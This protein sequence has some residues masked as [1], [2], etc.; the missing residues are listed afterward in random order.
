MVLA[1]LGFDP[2]HHPADWRDIG[3]PESGP[4][5]EGHNEYIEYHSA[6]AHTSLYVQENMIVDIEVLPPEPV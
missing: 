5:L 4:R 1:A 2:I 6:K 3:S